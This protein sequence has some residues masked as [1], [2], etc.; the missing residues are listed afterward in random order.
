MNHLTEIGTTIAL[1]AVFFAAVLMLTGCAT[2]HGSATPGYWAPST[3]ADPKAEFG[4]L[5]KP[6]LP[7]PKVEPAK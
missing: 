4:I 6:T 2:E 3:P 7:A 1:I 5:V